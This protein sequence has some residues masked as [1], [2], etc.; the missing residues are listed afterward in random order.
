MSKAVSIHLPAR[1]GCTGLDPF[2]F[3]TG[4]VGT[5]KKGE[6]KHNLPIA[7]THYGADIK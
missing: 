6:N 4:T 7:E 3:F 5:L 1:A 2:R